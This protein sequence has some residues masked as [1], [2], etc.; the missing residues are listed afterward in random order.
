MRFEIEKNIFEHF[1]GMKIVAVVA[2]D[3]QPTE[4]A[5]KIT[6]ALAEAWQIGAAAATAYENPQSHPSIQPWGE[7]MK[8]LHAPR[9]QFPSS[10]EA[11]VRRA[12]KSDMPVSINPL[13]DFYNAVSLK[14]LVPAGGFD[15]DA[16]DN[17]LQ[18]RF[19]Q[20][21]DTFLALDSEEEIT[22][23]KGEVSYACGTIIITRHFVWKQAKHAI[24]MPGSKNVIFVS[25]VLGE[26]PPPTAADVG[27]ALVAGLKQYFGIET[28]AHILDVNHNSMEL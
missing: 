1:P 20:Q 21:G 4:H 15:L 25:E 26:L 14:Y 9:K 10:I 23:P 7:R 2:K 17:D 19:S 5:A 11:L 27:A 3:M 8:A 28:A 24:L 12:G 13:V 22:V 16:L 6:A 18:L